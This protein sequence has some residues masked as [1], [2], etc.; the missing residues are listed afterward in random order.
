MGQWPRSPSRGALPFGASDTHSHLIAIFHEQSPALASRIPS[1]LQPAACPRSR[2]VSTTNQS[3]MTNTRLPLRESRCR[4]A[5]QRKGGRTVMTLCI[6]QIRS[7]ELDAGSAVACRHILAR[8]CA[9]FLGTLELFV[10]DS[11]RCSL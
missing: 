3:M 9:C 6:D 7:L 5:M 11:L 8:L 10:L 2:R 4:R 1:P